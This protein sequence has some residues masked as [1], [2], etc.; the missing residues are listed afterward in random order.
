MTASEN[1][2][3]LFQLEISP[4]APDDWT[5]LLSRDPSAEY[6]QTRYWTE[7]VCTHLPG[8]RAVWLS[9]RRSGLLVGGMNVVERTGEK[10]LKGLIPGRRRLESSLEGT[11]GGPLVAGDL[12]SAEQ[13]H[14]FGMLIDGLAGLSL[15]PL[16]TIAMVLGP[17]QEKRFGPLMRKRPGW[18]RNEAPTAAVSL[19]GGIEQVQKSRLVRTKRNERNRGLRRGVEVFP[20]DEVELLREYY[21][22]YQRATRHWG[23]EPAPLAL[24][25]SL[26]LDPAG[27][28]FFICVRFEGKVI[29]GHLNLHYGDRILAWN[30]VTDPALS[31]SHFPGTLCFWGDLVEACLRNA[32]WLDMGGSGGVGSLV[33]FKK[34]FGAELQM[35]GLYIR[36]SRAAGILRKGRDLWRRRPGTGSTVRWHDAV[37]GTDK[38]ETP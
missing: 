31:R 25:E 13:D 7:A 17:A 11:S 28:V 4:R 18:V 36:D 16:G 37:A 23:V 3:D 29:G 32:A 21:G 6:T 26:L 22:I 1:I 9:L 8:A 2:A 34:Y 38:G 10:R 12:G 30:G 5:D 20:T 19:D 14:V 35:R 27:R 24:L 15:G 33:G